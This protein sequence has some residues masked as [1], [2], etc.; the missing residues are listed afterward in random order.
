MRLLTYL[1]DG[2]RLLGAL[3][4]DRVVDLAAA[5][6][7]RPAGSGASGDMPRIDR[8]RTGRAG[9]GWRAIWPQ[10]T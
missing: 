9:R 6:A 2:E 7:V 1:A 4:G 5:Q 8:G 10:T 3:M